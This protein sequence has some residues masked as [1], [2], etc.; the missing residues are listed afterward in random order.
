MQSIGG[1]GF[2]LLPR[3]HA[4]AY[5][6]CE[7]DT[8]ARSHLITTEYGSLFFSARI[9]ARHLKVVV[10]SCTILP[11]VEKTYG[12]KQPN[13]TCRTLSPYSRF[14][15]LSSDR[16]FLRQCYDTKKQRDEKPVCQK[17]LPA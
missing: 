11:V 17:M 7:K 8:L 1:L 2:V 10:A 4:N 14:L 15:C 6:N 9:L 16:D 3:K 13:F 12:V 5:L